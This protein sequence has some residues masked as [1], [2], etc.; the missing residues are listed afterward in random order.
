VAS[1]PGM[2]GVGVAI[3]GYYLR[4]Q[5]VGGERYRHCAPPQKMLIWSLNVFRLTVIWNENS[6]HKVEP[7]ALV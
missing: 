3:V 4:K 7:A 1:N 2:E 6:V 5:N